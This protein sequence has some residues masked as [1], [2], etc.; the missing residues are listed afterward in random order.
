MALG[1]TNVQSDHKLYILKIKNKVLDKETNKEVPVV[2]HVFQ[3]TEKVDGKW[4]VKPDTI[5]QFSGD[6]TKIDFDKGEW[7]G[8]EYHIVKFLFADEETKE[9]YLLDCRTSSDF[10]AL[11]NSVL[12]LDPANT[13][14]LKV[15]LYKTTSKKNGKDYSNIALW[16][17]ENHIKGKYTWEEMPAIEK[18]KFKGKD[19]SDTTKVDEWV[20]EKLKEFAAKIGKKTKSTSTQ[21]P[22]A[23]SEK[24]EKPATEKPAGGKKNTKKTET[25]HPGDV[26]D[27]D[28][29]F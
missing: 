7:E 23:A 17:G 8:S 18:V 16:Q 11:A 26:N 4:V 2:P 27:E 28:V 19:M 14:N 1:N 25:P 29:P 5:Y 6:L 13:A 21:A 12:A 10:R 3:I 9:N 24:S 15:S 20:I 22:V